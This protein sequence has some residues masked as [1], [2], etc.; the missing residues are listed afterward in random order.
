[1]KMFAFWFHS[2][3]ICLAHWQDLMMMTMCINKGQ[4][5]T[6]KVSTVVVG[7]LA[8]SC[9]ELQCLLHDAVMH[10]LCS[11]PESK[12]SKVT[13]SQVTC[14]QSEVVLCVQK[15]EQQTQQFFSRK[16]ITSWC[17]L[18]QKFLRYMILL[19]DKHKSIEE[20]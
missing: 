8:G 18:S 7:D 19:I 15:L 14:L 3:L 4:S 1:M 6:I 2:S 9:N 17:Q 10:I 11:K 5:G 16:L 12:E 13:K 20:R